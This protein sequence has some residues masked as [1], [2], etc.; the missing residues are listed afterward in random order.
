VSHYDPN[1][2]VYGRGMQGSM[3]YFQ[4]QL[5]QQQLAMMNPLQYQVYI[6]YIFKYMK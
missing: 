6:L 5:M 2:S 4:H 3:A 1:E